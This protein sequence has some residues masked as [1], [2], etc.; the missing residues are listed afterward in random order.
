LVLIGFCCYFWFA[1]EHV[2]RSLLNEKEVDRRFEVD[3]ICGA[4]E[5]YPA[6]SGG[7]LL[8][9]LAS[10]IDG[11]LGTYC[12]LFDEDFTSLSD[13]FPLFGGA[14]FDP[15]DYPDLV[16]AIWENDRGSMIVRFDG[17]GVTPH[18]LR[19]YYR[20]VT[21]NSESRRLLVVAGVSAFSVDTRIGDWIAWGAVA[22]IIVAAV[23]II[24]SVMLICRWRGPRAGEVDSDE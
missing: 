11:T 16:E 21:E 2:N 20:W 3:L 10:E 4:A 7:E 12:E 17:E 5:L 24:G 19:I 1:L 6:K 22:L 15:R 9:W 13:R 18:D 8:A 14:P 23:A